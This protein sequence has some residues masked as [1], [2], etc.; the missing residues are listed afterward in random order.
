MARM[1]LAICTAG[2]LAL[3]D[4]TLSVLARMTRPCGSLDI[5]I[6]D[7]RPTGTVTALCERHAAQLSMPLRVVEEPRLGL[8]SARNRAIREALVMGAE[9]VAFIDDDDDPCPDWL[10]ELTVVQEASG[11]DMVFGSWRLPPGAR[12]PGNSAGLRWL[13]PVRPD[14]RNRYGLP[15]WAGTYNVLLSRRLLEAL[16]HGDGPFRPA[17]SAC[18]G[19]DG[20]LFIRAHR[21]GFTWAIAERSIVMR[22][23]EP[24]RLTMLGLMR[25]DFKFGISR[26]HLARHHCPPP[27]HGGAGR[28]AFL[29][30]LKIAIRLPFVALRPA[31]ATRALVR[32]AGAAGELHAAVGGSYDYY[33]RTAPEDRRLVGVPIAVDATC[34]RTQPDR[35]TPC[36][37]SSP[38]APRPAPGR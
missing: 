13:E 31:K 1:V 27:A 34:R 6:V 4:S 9:I 12:L 25:H 3:L 35:T 26:Y 10:V 19:E 2:R 18:G 32:L 16:S 15:A 22:I 36:T 37:L 38:S 23:W 8:V 30:L 14:A 33:G 29:K 21:A 17:F 11:A 7:N 24:H 28:R 20:D 5:L